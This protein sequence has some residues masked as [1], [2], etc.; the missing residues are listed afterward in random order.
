MF[1]SNKKFKTCCLTNIEMKHFSHSALFC[2]RLLGAFF[3]TEILAEAYINLQNIP[4]KAIFHSSSKII[5][6]LQLHFMLF[7][8]IDILS[9]QEVHRILNAECGLAMTG[10]RYKYIST[11]FCSPGAYK[12]GVVAPFL[13]PIESSS[14]YGQL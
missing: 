2:D 1:T 7:Y 5:L 14:L 4:V 8:S 9:F 10:Q 3:Q 13:A 12:K 11:N 6:K